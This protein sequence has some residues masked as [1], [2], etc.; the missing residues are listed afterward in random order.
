MRS[1]QSHAIGDTISAW[2][3]VCNSYADGLAERA[4]QEL[5]LPADVVDHVKAQDEQAMLVLR[6]LVAI[7]LY[8][9]RHKTMF[10]PSAEKLVV[11]GPRLLSR[12]ELRAKADA[13]GH[14]ICD[15]SH[16]FRCKTCWC[17]SDWQDAHFAERVGQPC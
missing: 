14:S 1:H 17:K 10:V 12:N 13:Q 9:V 5:Q 8:Q 11:R 4:A 16:V 7:C 6:R 2:E 3:F 15:D